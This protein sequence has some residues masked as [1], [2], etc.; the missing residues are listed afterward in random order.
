MSPIR[1]EILDYIEENRA[2]LRAEIA[3]AFQSWEYVTK[4]LRRAEEEAERGFTVWHDALDAVTLEI[5]RCCVKSDRDYRKVAE[6]IFDL[7]RIQ[8]ESVWDNLLAAYIGATWSVLTTFV[9][10]AVGRTYIPG[11]SLAALQDVEAYVVGAFE[12]DA[13]NRVD[14]VNSVPERVI[15]NHPFI[16]GDRFNALVDAYRDVYE[17][18]YASAKAR[19]CVVYAAALRRRIYA[20]RLKRFVYRSCLSSD[21]SELERLKERAEARDTRAYALLRKVK[22]A[23][24]AEFEEKVDLLARRVLCSE[25]VDH[26]ALCRSG[27]DSDGWFGPE[28]V[29]NDDDKLAVVHVWR[30]L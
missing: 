6:L 19:D 7:K 16:I 20:N 26:F 30:M 14:S 8:A 1:N 10:S 13:S 21:K 28:P 4:P 22:N 9:A 23:D 25:R 15:D 29:L 27:V 24:A 17:E 5:A 18:R 12:I 3:V 11:T 2:Y